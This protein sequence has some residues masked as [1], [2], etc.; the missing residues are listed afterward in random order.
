MQ[1]ILNQDVAKLGKAGDLVEV[2]EGYGRNF[3]FPRGLAKE[4]DKGQLKDWENL[5]K[6]KKKKLAREEAQAME[7]KKHL[8]DRNVTISVSTGGGGKLFGSVTAAQVAEA[9][10]KQLETKVE[11]KNVK[12][13]EPIRQLGTFPCNIKLHPG[14]EVSLSVTVKA[15]K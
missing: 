1:V 9:V 14:I 7:V 6:A 8:Q 5:Q 3:L 13:S 11:K 12:L 4:A 2:S 10:E 15:E